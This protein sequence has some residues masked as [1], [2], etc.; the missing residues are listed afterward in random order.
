MT[1]RRLSALR[2]RMRDVGVDTFLVT[3][4]T[5]VRY[6]SSFTG[7]N[8]TLV[9]TDDAQF[10]VTD[11]RYFEQAAHEAPDFQLVRQTGGL[12]NAIAEALQLAGSRRVA[13]E[14]DDV[15]VALFD[16]LQRHAPQGVRFEP[17]REVI[18]RLRAV[19]DADEIETLRRAQRITDE[20]F[21]RW[22]A[23]VQPGITEAELAW[24]LEIILR[25][26]GAQGPSFDIIV[27]VGDHSALPHYHPVPGDR[28]VRPNDIV[29]VDFGALVDG[30]HADMT[31]TLYVGDPDER[32]REVYSAV[33]EALHHA[34]THLRAGMS[35]RDAD[36]L[37]RDLLTARGFGEAFGHSLGHGVG[38]EIHEFPRLSPRAAED[39]IVP[40]HSVVT[41]EPGIYLPG[42]G[43]VRI[44]DL[45]VVHEDGIEILTRSPKAV[46]FW[47]I[48]AAY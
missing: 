45:A 42:W 34:E 20:A 14:A 12:P 18:I 16:E 41:I 25:E 28:A 27:A 6:L 26:L 22:V 9:I 40:A 48:H 35:N 24:K 23:L 43:G 19:K 10:I 36:A 46:D 38:L 32:F 47:K 11:F 3:N 30:Y 37:A 4:A 17:T 31:R 7:S 8:G 5:N 2:E 1:Q 39:E 44:E 15:T 13:F 29:L 33:L 21:E